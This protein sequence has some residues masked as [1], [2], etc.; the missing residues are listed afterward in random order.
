MV[1]SVC[2]QDVLLGLDCLAFTGMALQLLLLLL[3][4]RLGVLSQD[5][6]PGVGWVL[7]AG[8][9]GAPGS[10]AGHG[11][12]GARRAAGLQNHSPGELSAAKLTHCSL[13]SFNECIIQPG[14]ESPFL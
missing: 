2:G 14:C 12:G 5:L 1:K 9:T 3:A 6:C 8:A 7:G 10:S 4:A 11:S 13:S